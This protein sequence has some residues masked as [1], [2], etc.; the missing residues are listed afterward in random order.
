[1][2]YEKI[3]FIAAKNMVSIEEKYCHASEVFSVVKLICCSNSVSKDILYIL[4]GPVVN[5]W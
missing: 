4:H 5:A 2:H 3:A 1:M